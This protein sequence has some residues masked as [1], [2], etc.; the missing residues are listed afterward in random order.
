[1]PTLPRSAARHYAWSALLI[2]RALRDANAAKAA[3]LATVA[4]VIGQHQ[5]AAAAQGQTAVGLMLAEQGIE[6]APLARLNPLSFTTQ[7]SRSVGMLEQVKVDAEFDRL[8]SSLVSDAGRSAE[9][10]ATTVRPR[11]G[12]VRLSVAAV[13]LTVRGAR[14]PGLPVLASVP[15][16]SGLRLHDGPHDARQRPVRTRPG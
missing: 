12:Y 3:G 7:L 8:V 10:V 6:A 2:Q 11:I 9:S 15:T 1:M 13:L 16:A 4:T 5:V 14:G